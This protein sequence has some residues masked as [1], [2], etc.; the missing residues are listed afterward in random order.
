V[1]HTAQHPS[2]W[3]AQLCYFGH[4]EETFCQNQRLPPNVID[5]TWST[6][7]LVDLIENIGL[8][9]RI[10]D[11]APIG[12]AHQFEL[13]SAMLHGAYS[14]CRA[15]GFA[16]SSLRSR[17]HWVTRPCQH[18]F[19]SLKFAFV[20]PLFFRRLNAR[21]CLRFSKTPLPESPRST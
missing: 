9:L 4:A 17:L 20:R 19:P 11:L 8:A 7:S 16:V 6:P 10:H 12:M 2:L 14:M 18:A 5:T 3:T 21:R 1:R 13:Q 15:D